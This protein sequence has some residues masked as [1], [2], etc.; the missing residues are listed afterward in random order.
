M[1]TH[2]ERWLPAS[3][4]SR[5]TAGQVFV[6]APVPFISIFLQP[7]PMTCWDPGKCVAQN[8]TRRF[9]ASGIAPFQRLGKNSCGRIFFSSRN[10]FVCFS[11][12]V[13]Q[14]IFLRAPWGAPS[15]AANTLFFRGSTAPKLP[16][17]GYTNP[18]PN[19][20]RIALFGIQSEPDTGSVLNQA[21]IGLFLAIG[22]IKKSAQTRFAG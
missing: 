2:T 21:Q 6:R 11:G 3:G 1:G 13:R 9:L 10:C 22:Q 19:R 16:D 7:N 15:G 12:C 18:G 5:G 14:I 4:P 20:A 17:P 8:P